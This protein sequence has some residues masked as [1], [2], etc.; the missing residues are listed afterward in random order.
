[1]I[2]GQVPVRQ[3]F[4]HDTWA[5]RDLPVLDA[6]IGLL[7][8]SYMV[9][10]TDIAA[11][12][13]LDPSVVAQALEALDPVYVDFRKTTTGGDPRFWYVFKVTPEARRAVGQWPTAEALAGRL[14]DE[15]AAAARQEADGERQGLLSYAA[16]L[17]GDT[18]REAT[19]RAAGAVLAPAFGGIPLPEKG[20]PVPP[21]EPQQEL[22][23]PSLVPL[24]ELPE[25]LRPDRPAAAAQPAPEPEPE[26]PVA[27][28]QES[29]SARGP[30]A[31][32]PMRLTEVRQTPV[33][34]TPVQQTPVQQT[35]VQQTPAAPEAEPADAVADLNPWPERSDVAE[36]RAAARELKPLPDASPSPSSL[37]PAR[38]AATMPGDLGD[39]D[40]TDSADTDLDLVQSRGGAA[41]AV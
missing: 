4:V 41:N 28:G 17:V 13:S 3:I 21:P 34:Q 31:A 26:L 39:S 9:T 25:L 10:V 18:L 32:A 35:P 8:H 27:P 15:L 38:P 29:A 33:Q 24:P 6:T 7:E 19:V 22:D 16:R 20:Q 2:S 36:S 40:D 11:K 5:V 30:E 1:M 23:F 14:A 12:T 37:T